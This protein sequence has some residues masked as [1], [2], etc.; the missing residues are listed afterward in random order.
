MHDWPGVHF[1]RDRRSRK[2]STTGIQTSYPRFISEHGMLRLLSRPYSSRYGFGDKSTPVTFTLRACHGIGVLLR[3]FLKKG[4]G[5]IFRRTDCQDWGKGKDVIG[6]VKSLVTNLP[7]IGWEASC[8]RDL[9]LRG[10]QQRC[11]PTVLVKKRHA[12][13][14][15]ACNH[16]PNSARPCILGPCSFTGWYLEDGCSL[17][18]FTSHT[19]NPRR[20]QM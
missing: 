10:S 20:V 2:S 1:C 18:T 14:V 4:G 7:I 11:L 13:S 9:G 5:P 17:G 8:Y 3:E 15:Y 12:M 6:R 16:G 19:H